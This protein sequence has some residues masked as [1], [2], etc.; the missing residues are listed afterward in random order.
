M[1]TDKC[2]A[3]AVQSGGRLESWMT[4]PPK[5]AMW[6]FTPAQRDEFAKA[7]EAEVRKED[8]ALIRQMLEAAELGRTLVL[9]GGVF[10]APE[11]ALLATAITAA[12][13]R[14]LDS[15]LSRL[16]ERGKEAWKGVDPQKLRETRAL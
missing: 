2:D 14:L 13:A 10:T 11:L 8:E 16:T 4:N 12:R 9:T 6:H 15:D 5:P 3:L 1:A 7:I